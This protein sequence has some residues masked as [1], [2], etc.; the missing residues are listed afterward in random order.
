MPWQPGQQPPLGKFLN[1]VTLPGDL[2]DRIARAAR[3]AFAENSERQHSDD[4][5]RATPDQVRA[6]IDATERAVSLFVSLRKRWSVGQ[7]GRWPSVPQTRDEPC[8]SDITKPLDDIAAALETIDR[9]LNLLPTDEVVA[10][11]AMVRLHCKARVMNAD[12]WL[13][14]RE[15]EQDR[16]TAVLNGGSMDVY[17][18]ES[19]DTL[20][21]ASVLQVLNGA[22]QAR[23]I[24]ASTLPDHRQVESAREQFLINIAWALHEHLGIIPSTRK[25]PPSPFV[26]ILADLFAYLHREHGIDE[27][28]L[29]SLYK[30][31][32]AA[33]KAAFSDF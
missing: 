11:D 1:G 19:T 22:T 14:H 27:P 9:A 3:Q 6:F 2:R 12:D 13:N 18:P 33:K 15:E 10:L 28:S 21:L 20:S 4:Y 26:N 29:P 23:L 8:K 32:L 30:L 24:N 25:E 5:P 16:L 17:L 7:A 31:A